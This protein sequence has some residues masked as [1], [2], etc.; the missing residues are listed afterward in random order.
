MIEPTKPEMPERIARPDFEA[1]YIRAKD[2]LSKEKITN[3][4]LRKDLEQ[5]EKSLAW[6]D[7]I[8]QTVEVI[9]GREF[10]NG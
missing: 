9:F 2:E 1:M 8:K 3:D 4:F 7:G 10:Y 5:K 6:Y